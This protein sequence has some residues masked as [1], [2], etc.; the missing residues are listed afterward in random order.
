VP[1][2]DGVEAMMVSD[3]NGRAGT[4]GISSMAFSPSPETAN[5]RTSWLP[6][7]TSDHREQLQGAD[8]GPACGAKPAV[9]CGVRPCVFRHLIP[10]GCLLLAAIGGGARCLHLVQFLG[11]LGWPVP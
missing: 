1:R 6:T 2:R 11:L 9:R 3:H 8:K 7:N 10:A 4:K 5:R